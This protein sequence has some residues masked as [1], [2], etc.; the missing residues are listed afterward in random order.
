MGRGRARIALGA[1]AALLLLAVAGCGAQSH[2][3]EPRPEP[4]TRV[5][6]TIAPGAVTVQP[7]RVGSG[8]DRSQQIPQNQNHAQPRIHTDRP[9]DV[10]FVTSNQTEFDSHLELHGPKRA[11]SEPVLAHSPGTFQAELPAGVYTISAADIPG[12]KPG[13]L[14]IGA[15]RASSQ[16]DVLLP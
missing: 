10:I 6:V 5:S 7:G 15:F 13:K 11:N 8:P 14:V 3:N 9:L 1:A 2:P 16:N 4:P 12:A